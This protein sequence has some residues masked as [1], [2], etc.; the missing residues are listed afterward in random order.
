MSAL[1]DA[2]FSAMFPEPVSELLRRKRLTVLPTDKGEIASLCLSDD[3][4]QPVGK[5]YGHLSTRL[6]RSHAEGIANHVLAP[7]PHDVR[8]PEAR[9][10]Q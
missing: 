3:A 2:C 8:S 1:F 9:T 4:H 10:Q 5:L 7:C 6:L